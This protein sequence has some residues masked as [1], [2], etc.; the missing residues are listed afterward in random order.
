MS[1]IGRMR[2]SR[3]VDSAWQLAFR[4]GYP[5]VRAWWRVWC[6]RHEGA[7]VAIYVGQ[8][9]LLVRSSY[10][11]VWNFPGG[12]IQRGETPEAAAR[13]ELAEEIG[14]RPA[15][16]LAA[17]SAYGIWD[18]RRHRVHFFELRLDRLPQLQLDNREII[19]ARFVSPDALDR[20][21]LTGPVAAFLGRSP[22]P[23]ADG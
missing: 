2:P 8:A 21:A 20:M 11:T 17:G 7:L 16:L 4:L 15:A 22:A 12:G 14:L 13:R 23:V 1:H 6:P 9:L 19:A 18:G 3:F 5:L 10:R